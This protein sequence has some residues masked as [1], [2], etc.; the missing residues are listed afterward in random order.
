MNAPAAPAPARKRAPRKAASPAKAPAAT[1]TPRKRAPRKPAPQKAAPRKPPSAVRGVVTCPDGCCS[2]KLP[3]GAI[4]SPAR[5]DRA[6]R[7]FAE[8][9]RHMKGRWAGQP[10][11][12]EHWQEWGIIRP[13]FGTLE[14]KTRLRWY[15]EAL[16]GLARKNGKS[17]L[18]AGIA[19][20]L[21][22]ADGEFGAEVYSLA[23]DKKQ[24][25][26]VYKAACD[27][28]KASPFRTAVRPYRSVMEVPETASLYRALSSD[29]DLQ[30]GLNPHGAVVDEY[31]VH[32]DSEQYEAMRTG[33]A[34]RLQPLIVTIT[35]AG[36]VK[37]GPLWL[38]YSRAMSG[39]SPRLFVYWVGPREGDDLHDPANW[40]LWNPA[41][42]VTMDFLWEQHGTP[43]SVAAEQPSLPFP[44]F[45]RLH[46]NA[47]Y[48]GTGEGWVTRDQLAGC[49]GIPVIDA[50]RS[51]VLAVDAASKRDT[52]AV[53]AVQR[54][55]DGLFHRRCWHFSADPESGFFDYGVLEDLVRE[56]CSTFQ[57]Q[58]VAFDPYQMVRTSQIL[59]G[60]GVP[61]ETFPQSD[62]R[63]VPASQ[64]LYDLIVEGRLVI[65]DCPICQEQILAAAV[66]ETARGWRIDRLRSGPVD[67]A[68]AL[69]MGV[70]LAEWEHALEGGPRVWSV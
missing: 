23:G 32:R 15:R 56:L 27:M 24:A 2:F 63:M 10:F 29:A 62:T 21:L 68:I 12:L 65:D 7:F 66:R 37:K 44:V 67:S 53:M 16:I 42:W 54:D 60:E 59:Q 34:A 25:T 9:L 45:A 58:R 49:V 13:L 6:V 28:A 48:E 40:R 5:A 70:Q 36:G 26:L 11:I 61:V 57:V 4:Y 14:R 31:H 55:E 43:E 52:T 22:V 33:T 38:L 51:V 69:A 30:H 8:Y 35:T 19:L 41:S 50:E 1:A 20:Y 18:A 64:L 46:L 39:L 47:W 3:K 17:E